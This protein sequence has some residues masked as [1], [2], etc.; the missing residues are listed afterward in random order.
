V[1]GYQHSAPA[2]GVDPAQHAADAIAVGF[3]AATAVFA[4][5]LVAG[6]FLLP[7]GRAVA[8]TDRPAAWE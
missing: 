6:W 8:A 1:L 2:A 3:G 7:R 4:V 5:A